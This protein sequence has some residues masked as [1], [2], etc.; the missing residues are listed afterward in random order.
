MPLGLAATTT[1]GMTALATRTGR[2]GGVWRATTTT[3]RGASDVA[4][5]RGASARARSSTTEVARATA[6]GSTARVTTARGATTKVIRGAVWRTSTE[7]ARAAVR[8][9]AA[10]V[11]T[12]LGAATNIVRGTVW[13]ASTGVIRSSARSTPADVTRVV[14][15]TAAEVAT[16]RTRGVI[17]RHR[18]RFGMPAARGGT[19]TMH[20]GARSTMILRPMSRGATVVRHRIRQPTMRAATTRAYNTVTRKLTRPRSRCDSGPTVVERRMQLPVAS[21]A[22]LM[23]PLHRRRFKVMVTLGGELVRRRP[24]MQATSAAIE[25]HVVVVVDNSVVV[26]VGHM[27]ATEVGARA[28]IE[29][30]A[31]APVA[32]REPNTGITKPVVHTAV[33]ADVRT[34]VAAVPEVDTTI[35]TPITRRPEN[36][37]RGRQHPRAGHPVI[38]IVA[39]RPITRRPHVAR[40]GQ[41]RLHVNRKN[42]RRHGDRH[43]YGNTG[44]RNRGERREH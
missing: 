10:R 34:P 29:K 27:N 22:G 16:T 30:R 17:A 44:V 4:S 41:G 31:T 36:S 2:S 7:V 28:V 12:A 21:G 24:R 32:T 23:L 3:T 6:L 37:G 42:R 40:R 25:G 43:T 18:V 13:R 11:A 14:L 19:A 39:P 5:V 38:T 8:D 1:V 35:P 15:G 20:S 33:E 26:D 9:S